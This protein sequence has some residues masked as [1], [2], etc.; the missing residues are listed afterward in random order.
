MNLSHLAKL[1]AADMDAETVR[2]EPVTAMIISMT[3]V[4]WGKI[5]HGSLCFSAMFSFLWPCL[6]SRSAR[7]RTTMAGLFHP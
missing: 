3:Q 6:T 7:V 2:I 5:S 4:I 1:L